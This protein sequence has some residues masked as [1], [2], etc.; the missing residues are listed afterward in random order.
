MTQPNFL[1][2]SNSIE[3]VCAFVDAHP[4]VSSSERYGSKLEALRRQW[5]AATSATDRSYIGWRDRVG[6]E[7]QAVRSMK[8][9]VD[10]VVELADEHGYHD[11]PRRRVV[12]DDAAQVFALVEDTMSWL[13]SKGADW[14]WIATM[15]AEIDTLRQASTA[16]RG[17][18]AQCYRD[19]CVEVKRRVEA[20]DA[21]VALLREY[22]RDAGR[23]SARFDDFATLQLDVL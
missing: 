21:A 18:A 15:T 7:L 23:D 13:E 6:A 9:A 20:Y 11:V 16:R 5:D 2:V 22:L 10:R 4:D 3:R 1:Q 8:L 12:Y 14:P 19:Y 17:E